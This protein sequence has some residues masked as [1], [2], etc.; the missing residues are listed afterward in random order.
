MYCNKRI[1]T[2]VLG[3]ADSDECKTWNICGLG[4]VCI[5]T[6]GSYKCNCAEGYRTK[7][8]AETFHPPTDH[9]SCEGKNVA[10]NE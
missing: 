1:I 9:I 10:L 7:N 6:V 2:T 4:G 8:G 3:I 5:N